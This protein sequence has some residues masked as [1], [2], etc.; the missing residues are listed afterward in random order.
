MTINPRPGRCLAEGFALC[1]PSGTISPLSFRT[2]QIEAITSLFALEDWPS[3]ES[4]GWSVEF[5][6]VRMFTPKFFADVVPEEKA[7][8]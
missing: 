1:T 8:A 5:V 6:Y 4:E 3:R 2:S 7:V